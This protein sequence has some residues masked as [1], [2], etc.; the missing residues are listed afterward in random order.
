MEKRLN[1]VHLNQKDNKN[2]EIYQLFSL[3]STFSIKLDFFY[4]LID[5]EVIFFNH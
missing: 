1:L 3:N 2:D 5:I 4:L